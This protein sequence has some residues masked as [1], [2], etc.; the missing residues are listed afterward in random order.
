MEHDASILFSLSPLDGR[1]A[2]KVDDLRAYLSEYALMHHRVFVEVAWL[3]ALAQAGFAELPPLSDV[4]VDKLGQMVA[5]FSD[6]DA[7][8]IKEIEQT[9]NHDVKAVEYWMREQL[10]SVPGSE[11]AQNF[12]HFACTSEDINNLAHGIMLNAAREK[13][14]WPAVEGVVVRLTSI[15]QQNAGVSM[16][17]RTHG[18]AA[19]PTTLGKE[20]A[21]FA[22]RLKRAQAQFATIDLMGKLN[23]A[24]GNYNA[25]LAA[26]PEHDWE[27]FNRSVVEGM[28]LG[29]NPVTTQIEP[30]DA[31]AELF[32]ATARMNTIGI[33]LCRDVW[34]YI[35]LGYFTQKLKQGEIGS[36]TMPHKV[37]PIDFENAEGNFGVAN[38]TLRML[39]ERLPISRWQRD[40]T[41]STTLRNMGVAFG[42][43]LLA[44]DSL[45]KGLNKLQVAEAR[46]AS[47]LDD[48]WEVLGEAIQTV[49]RRYNVPNAYEKLKELT[50]GQ[51]ITKEALREF[52]AQLDLPVPARRALLTL[53]PAKYIGKAAE[54]ALQTG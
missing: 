42:H 10:Q 1:Y 24:T 23:G 18:Q 25:H 40:L 47:D 22:L 9:T 2:H 31:M 38:A 43:T 51:K 34:G 27:S 11:A 45:L 48:N 20:I 28:G 46:I 35:S 29:F 26:Y 50:R 15:A 13:V 41:D 39:S 6:R 5:Q 30:H 14:I 33:D 19:T 4:V 49:M 44:F 3:Q 12:I 52:I 36:S 32:D 37:N 21:V 54:L 8:R 16:L 7:L 17:A 53:T